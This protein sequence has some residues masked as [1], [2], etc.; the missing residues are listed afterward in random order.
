MSCIL[1]LERWDRGFESHSRHGC[2]YCVRLFCV[3][4]VLCGGRGAL[5]QA[6]SPSKESYRLCIGSRKWKSGQGST[7]ECRAIIIIIIT[8]L[9]LYHLIWGCRGGQWVVMQCSL[10]ED[11]RNVGEL[12][13]NWIA[14]QTKGLYS[15]YL[16]L[17]N[18]RLHR[19]F[20]G[21][22]N[23]CLYG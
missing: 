19:N 1:P 23:Q 15:L 10:V 21:I 6:A 2:L 5:R 8:N 12:L 18:V 17:H 16:Y 13:L 3:H 4:V 22:L 20:Q 14:L 11:L 7:K 9:R